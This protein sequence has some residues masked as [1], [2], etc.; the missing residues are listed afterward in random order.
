[1]HKQPSFA[2]KKRKRMQF[3]DPAFMDEPNLDRLHGYNKT[4]NGLEIGHS[5][6]QG[7]RTFMEDEYIISEMELK[8]H[9]IVAIMDGKLMR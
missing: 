1:M 6:I 4:I 3:N 9:T 2:L 8:G 5:S 7:Y